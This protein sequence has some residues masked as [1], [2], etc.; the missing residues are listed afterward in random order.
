L[1]LNLRV[2]DWSRLDPDGLLAAARYI[3]AGQPIENDEQAARLHDLLTREP[4]RNGPRHWHLEQ[5]MARR[6]EALVEAVRMLNSHRD[7]IVRVM[8]R[9]GYTDPKWVG[10]FLDRDLP[11]A[12]P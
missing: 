6:P 12:T 1:T 4:T 7:E 2:L 10:G 3:A 11:A 8:T 5:L 9:Y